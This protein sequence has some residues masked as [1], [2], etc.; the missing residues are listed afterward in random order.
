MDSEVSSVSS[1]NLIVVG[2]SCINSAAAALVGGTKCGAAWTAAT[3]I[4]SGQF[5]IRGYADSTITT[6]LALLVAGYDAEDTV[7]ATTYLLN[8][9]VDTSKAYKGTTTTETAVVI[10]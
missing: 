2:G 5:L 8:K 3:G 7:K 10:D 1:K 4:G 9:P 6:G